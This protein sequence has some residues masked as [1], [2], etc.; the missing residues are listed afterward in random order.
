I[1]QKD[2]RF[3]QRSKP[4]HHWPEA[5]VR[6]QYTDDSTWEAVN[7]D[8]LSDDRRIGLERRAPQPIADDRGAIVALRRGASQERAAARGIDAQRVEEIRTD[9]ERG[10]PQRLAASGELRVDR[11]IGREMI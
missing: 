11:G 3:R 8:G 9:V 5:E 7:G 4:G 10:Q 6:R 1:R 2:V